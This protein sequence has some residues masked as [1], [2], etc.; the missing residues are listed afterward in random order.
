MNIDDLLGLEIYEETRGNVMTTGIKKNADVRAENIRLDKTG[1]RFDLK[2]PKGNREIKSKLIGK[3]NVYNILSA[4]GAALSL[5]VSLDDVVRGVEVL[6][7]VPGRFEQIDLGQD[8]T[9]VVDYAHT[10]DAIANIL[11]VA[12]EFTGGRILTV[13]G[14]GGDRDHGKRAEMGRIAVGLSDFTVITSDNPRTEDPEKIMDDIRAGVPVHLREK[15][16]YVCV[17]ERR[18][19]IG[20]SISLA[21]SGDIVMVVGKGHEDYQILDSQTICFDDREVVRET[22]KERLGL[23]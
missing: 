22:L 1:A 6:Q 2:T 18:E 12:R 23:G 10:G 7:G 4:V 14:C 11:G 8:F 9:V 3:H 13:F 15:G 19:A 5:D 16:R 17:P 20:Y 21:E